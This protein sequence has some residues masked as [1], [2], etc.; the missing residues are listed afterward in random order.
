MLQHIL[1][2]VHKTRPK[3]CS[4]TGTKKFFKFIRVN[5]LKFKIRESRTKVKVFDWNDSIYGFDNGNHST[6]ISV[7]ITLIQFS[8]KS[9]ITIGP[10][11]Q[12]DSKNNNSQINFPFLFLITTG[13]ELNKINNKIFSLI[14]KPNIKRESTEETTNFYDIVYFWIIFP[15]NFKL[16]HRALS[17]THSSPWRTP[18]SGHS[19]MEI[20]LQNTLALNFLKINIKKT[21]SVSHSLGV[22]FLLCCHG[23]P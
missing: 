6:L 11:F 7:R 20:V 8:F 12:P 1:K 4:L 17:F 23:L 18:S 15:T 2:L 13:F 9:Y 16:K 10:N 5:L 3:R 19:F 14:K 21:L 22:Q